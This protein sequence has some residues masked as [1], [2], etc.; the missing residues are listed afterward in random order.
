M[1][2][3]LTFACALL[4][5]PAPAAADTYMPESFHETI[6]TYP[7]QLFRVIVQG[8][9]AV[10]ASHV[11]ADV[12]HDRREAPAYEDGIDIAYSSIN[13]VAAE[14]TGKQI[15]LLFEREDILAITPDLPL[16]S[17]A[18]DPPFA[19]EPPTVTGL[20]QSGSQLDA[21][22]GQWS[23]AQPLALAYQWRRCNAAGTE[24]AEIPGAT[25]PG[26]VASP[27]DIGSTLAAAVTATNDDGSAS[28]VSVATAV[29]V[30]GTY[31]LAPGDIGS[32]LGVLISTAPVTDT[33]SLPMPAS[34]PT[35]AIPAS[36][37]D[38]PTIEGAAQVGARLEAT[39]AET[40]L[41]QRCDAT[42]ETCAEIA[43]AET[44][45]YVPVAADVGAT[46]RV[47]DGTLV[48]APTAVVLPAAPVNTAPPTIEG[49]SVSG[50]QLEAL[51]GDWASAVPLTYHYRWQ[52]C[53]PASGACVDVATTSTY[54]AGDADI[55]ATL[56]VVVRATNAGGN[57]T[58]TSART[59]R[60]APDSP[61]GLW[62]WQ[63]GPYAAGVDAQ[64]AAVAGAGVTPPAIA[65]VDSGVDSALP[66]L[67]GAVVQSATLTSLPQAA[68]A[69]SYGHGS[70]VAQVAA[71]RAPGE[72]GAAPT[73]P[74]VSL[75]VMD[76]NGMALTSDVVAA[77]DWIYTHK[78][79]SGI[80]VAN[81]S[82]VG[83]AKSTF[84][85]DP[86][87]RALERL[88]LSGVVVVAAAGNYGNGHTGDVAL[89]PANDPFVLTVGATDTAGTLTK[90]DDFAAPWS[91]FGH[92][93]DGFAKPELG[94]P[95][96][97]VVARVPTESTLY[98]TRTDRIVAPG[99]LQLSGTSFAAPLVAGVAANLL[100]L[101]PAWTPDQVKGALMVSAAP[102][103]AAAP[104]SVGVGLLDAAAAL[105]VTDP[106]N[107]N[108]ALDE[109]VV[110]DPSG[111]ATPVFDTASWGTAV[112]ANASWGT[113]SWGTASWG[114]AYWSS[115]SWG[116]A[117]WGTASWGTASWGTDLG[118]S[119]GNSTGYWMSWPR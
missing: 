91:V 21:T 61:S 29:V 76:D 19:V 30:A 49:A 20:A 75:D 23:G 106:P 28:A 44:S 101:H 7:R 45:T 103:T 69:D 26:Y 86:L 56:R 60:V 1:L 77:A 10:S 39:G 68:G 4:A 15:L 54:T 42:G 114:T 100:A 14:L 16:R 62:S 98:R 105:A 31:V 25:G 27:D 85:Y 117:S 63:L 46:L 36:H 78:S 65:V 6:S 8:R 115:A 82:L 9:P 118:L 84:Q 55:G 13:A 79:E 32:S 22:P 89:A 102:A 24:C 90:D 67:N 97:Y 119:D 64:W 58:R 33:P 53:D 37:S 83:S 87:D 66:G 93:Y 11:K 47:S 18:A 95:G 104:F 73:A 70:F 96:R 3:V 80:G 112:Q 81:F 116:T 74:I 2:A 111:D 59:D 113:A 110:S 51:P 94:A 99:L 17:V 107:P 72:A 48:S 108:A 57:R 5:A 92:T 40:Y 43:G 88:W 35:I 41:W 71:G 34:E 109:F 52:R 12:E 38:P 50:A